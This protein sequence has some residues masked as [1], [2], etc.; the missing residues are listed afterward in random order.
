MPAVSRGLKLTVFTNDDEV[1]NRKPLYHEI[2]RRA[3]AAGMS[4]AMVMRGIEG[5]GEDGLVHTSRLLSL[6]DSLPL[7]VVVI[8][9]EDRVRGFL[10]QL[11]ELLKTGVVTLEEVEVTTYASNPE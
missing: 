8:D 10:P 11:S 9:T 7:L 1:W 5:Y 3:R 6:S 4:R 2:V